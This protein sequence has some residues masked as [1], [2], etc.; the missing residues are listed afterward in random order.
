VRRL[1]F[2]TAVGVVLL[3]SATALAANSPAPHN[4]D[5]WE[6]LNRKFYSF[7]EGLDHA[8]LRPAAM[9]YAHVLPSPLRIGLRNLLS[10]AS[11]PPVIINYVL[12]A[13]F[14]HAGSETGRFLLNTVAGVGGLFDIATGAGLEHQGTNFGITLGR[15]GAKPG[16]YVYLPIGGPTTV[17]GLIGTAVGGAL[18]PLYWINYPHKTAVSIGRAVVSGLDLRAE[19]DS[20]LKSLLA[21]A[22]DPY[23]TIRSA[24]LQNLQSQV[25]GGALP[26]QALPDFDDTTTPPPATANPGTA[27]SP[28]TP[29]ATDAPSPATG[30]AEPP[31]AQSPAPTPAP[32]PAQPAAPAPSPA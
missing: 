26:A 24:Y 29:P 19:A 32:D 10:N 15:W 9:A 13:R 8:I 6:R 17:R 3:N 28:A 25:D 5:P 27:A 21:D 1:I 20:S 4:D 11:E 16:P 31:A 12:Q 23:A 18:D 7:S 14:H 2:A 22:T 30:H